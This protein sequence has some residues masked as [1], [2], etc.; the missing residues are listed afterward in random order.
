MTTCSST[1]TWQ[2]LRFVSP[3][4]NSLLNLV[5]Q[6]LLLT[7]PESPDQTAHHL[8]GQTLLSTR[9]ELDKAR[10]NLYTHLLDADTDAPAGNA[11]TF[12]SDELYS[13][14]IIAGSDTTF[15]TMTRFF[16]AL[17]MNPKVPKKMQHKID[18]HWLQGKTCLSEYKNL[19]LYKRSGQR[20]SPPHEPLTSGIC[21]AAPP[22]GLSLSVF[23]DSEKKSF[24]P[25]NVQVMIPHLALRT[26]VRY[27]PRGREFI[28]ERWTGEW[29]DGV[30]DRR[31]FIPFG[32]GVH[33]CVG[34]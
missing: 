23:R 11:L 28:P 12:S 33:N 2:F 4:L 24:I 30:R 27:F 20:V 34:Q 18:Q 14:S 22:S 9:L 31:A 16:Q 26:D 15:S 32:Y 29:R 13:N 17:A 10:K 5:S 25:R 19:R 1:S 7:L 8:R 6:K 3:S 21:A